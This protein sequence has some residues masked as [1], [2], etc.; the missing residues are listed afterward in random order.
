MA[1]NRKNWAKGLLA[2]CLLQKRASEPPPSHSVNEKDNCCNLSLSL[3]SQQRP[4]PS[5]SSTGYMVFS[6][7][8]NQHHQRTTFC[9]KGKFCPGE[10]MQRAGQIHYC[11]VEVVFSWN[12]PLG[13]EQSEERV[14]GQAARFLH[15]IQNTRFSLSLFN[16]EVKLFGFPV[17]GAGFQVDSGHRQTRHVFPCHWPYLGH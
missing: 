3:W 15:T 17:R 10:V 14:P 9:D 16:S 1:R 4:G 6:L 7:A 11:I 8:W 12:V 13:K 5:L 2:T